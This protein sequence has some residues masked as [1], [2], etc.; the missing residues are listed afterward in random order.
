MRFDRSKGGNSFGGEAAKDQGDGEIAAHETRL[1]IGKKRNETDK[2][3][4]ALRAA[5]Q[6]QIDYW[7]RAATCGQW[8]PAITVSGCPWAVVSVT[9][10]WPIWLATVAWTLLRFSNW[11]RKSLSVG[12]LVL[13]TNS[14]VWR[15]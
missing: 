2:T 12:I 4:K 3:L 9:T 14:D 6:A 1:S 13:K 15:V 10:R 8:Y 7:K 11:M 5:L